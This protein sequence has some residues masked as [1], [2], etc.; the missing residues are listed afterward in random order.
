MIFLIPN[1]GETVE[2]ID[3]FE[4][5]SGQGSRHHRLGKEHEPWCQAMGWPRVGRAHHG[6]HACRRGRR[7]GRT[8]GPEAVCRPSVG[9]PCSRNRADRRGHKDSGHDPRLGAGGRAA[10]SVAFILRERHRQTRQ[11]SCPCTGRALLQPPARYRRHH[12]VG[13]EG[14]ALSGRRDPSASG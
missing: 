13:A 10:R 3:C 9:L 6:R 14:R 8:A 12:R 4:H 7:G 11:A 2:G 5:S 1:W